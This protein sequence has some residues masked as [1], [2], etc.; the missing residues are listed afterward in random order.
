MKKVSK[1]SIILLIVFTL[2]IIMSS[3]KSQQACP[4]FGEVKK[5]QKEVRR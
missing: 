2:G 5:Y 4:A 3:C 1:A